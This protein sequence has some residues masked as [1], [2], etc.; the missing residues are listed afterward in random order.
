MKTGKGISLFLAL[1]MCCMAVLP[2]R[3]ASDAVG[4][5]IRLGETSGTVGVADAAGKKVTV[6]VDM[7]L[8][9]CYTVVTD[10]KST[11]HITLDGTK[12]VRLDSSGKCEIKK[13][14]KRLEVALVSGNL[15]FSVDQPLKADESFQIRTATMVTGVRGSF[16]WVNPTE[17]GMIHGHATVTCTNSVTGET[18]TT[19]MYSAEI[20]RFE[21]GAASTDPAL[22]QIDF[23]KTD[24]TDRDVPAVASEAVAESREKQDLIDA[25]NNEEL[26]GSGVAES[27]EEKREAQNAREDTAK[28]QSDAA[29]AAQTELVSAT[30]TEKSDQVFEA[31]AAPASTAP[32]EQGAT[33]IRNTGG[34]PSVPTTSSSSSSG[35]GSGAAARTDADNSAELMNLLSANA[36]ATLSVSGTM[37]YPGMTIQSGQTLTL[38]GSGR[39]NMDQLTIAAGGTVH[40]SEG[41]TLGLSGTDMEQGGTL[42]IDAGGAAAS[43]AEQVFLGTSALINNG[44]FSNDGTLSFA[45]GASVTGA[46][47]NTGTVIYHSADSVSV[48]GGT[49]IAY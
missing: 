29:V 26:T 16:G 22:Q 41:V 30:T 46:I 44:A 8:Y 19:E 9:N 15:Y 27:A 28:R 4:E 6:R 38:S 10:V 5:T 36:N 7:R 21:P 43:S 32:Q 40:V 39:V 45:P 14:G 17:S 25:D 42:R 34:S 13:N 31:Q 20:I 24:M 12:A 33:P 3:A 49:A 37:N 2:A 23:A 18:Y 35:G 48:S 47:T 11:A 1:L